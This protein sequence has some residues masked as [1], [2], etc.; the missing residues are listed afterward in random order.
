VFLLTGAIFCAPSRSVF[1]QDMYS[2]RVGTHQ[3]LVPTFVYDKSQ[4]AAAG[5]LTCPVVDEK[6]GPA[7][8]ETCRADV[9]PGLTVNDFHLFE[10][11]KEQRIQTVKVEP[12]RSVGVRDNAGYFVEDS[13]TPRGKWSTSDFPGT[14]SPSTYQPFF[15]LIAYT[16]PGSAPG[17][18]HRI[19]VKVGRHNSYVYVRSQ[20]CNTKLSA[21]DPLNGT[22]FG[23][24]LAGYLVSPQTGKIGLSV[25]TS[26]FY[27]GAG[28]G[29][30]DITLEFPWASLKH[31]RDPGG[32][33]ATIGVLGVVDRK[34][35]TPAARFSDLGCCPSDHPK[36]YSD[37]LPVHH[38]SVDTSV[39]ALGLYP[40]ERDV[41]SLPTRYETQFNL[42]AGEYALKILLSDG[43]QF[44]RA[45]A[46]LNVEAYDG[47]QLAVSSV[48]LCKRFRDAVVAAQTSDTVKLA[49]KYVPLVS[50]GVQFTPTGDTTLRKGESLFAYFEVYEP[51]LTS[52]PTTAVQTEL[53]LTDV[54]TGEFKADS[55]PRSAADWIQPGKTV[56]PIADK[57]EADK[58]PPG[59]YRL[60]VQATDST[61]KSTVWRAAN[62]TV[63]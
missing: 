30:V 55:G 10:D 46:P 62:F 29:R 20:Y 14:S 49:P 13:N 19:K 12:I 2:I 39:S 33:D 54:K 36:L 52:A 17:S 45:E 37:A 15:Y 48:V 35:G 24:Q 34:D 3:V 44:G 32:L 11:G 31:G 43:S 40:K 50:K 38:G 58:L 56:I 51:L 4:V 60:E 23:N 16:P 27:A 57:I 6:G 59:L 8:V 42:P 47:K 28:A 61:G 25:Q 1:A 53:K 9:V 63:Q 18:C 22:K 5:S 7:V 26:F 41:Y 21:S